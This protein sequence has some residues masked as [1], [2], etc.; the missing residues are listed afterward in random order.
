RNSEVRRARPRGLLRCATADTFLRVENNAP[1]FAAHRWWSW[2]FGGAARRGIALRECGR[3]T[4]APMTLDLVPSSQ[5]VVRRMKND[6]CD[7]R[8]GRVVSSVR[9][10]R[11]AK[12]RRMEWLNL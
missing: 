7:A 6:R 8:S 9:V 11:R 4:G 3:E 10:S 1:A 2:R 5:K 12:T